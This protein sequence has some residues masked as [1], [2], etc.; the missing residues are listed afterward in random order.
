MKKS[1]LRQ[2]IKKTIEE[3][4]TNPNKVY[5]GS[6]VPPPTK[7]PKPPT[8]PIR[9]CS[10]D[11]YNQFTAAGVAMTLNGIPG[12]ME[13]TDFDMFDNLMGDYG[14]VGMGVYGFIQ[15]TCNND[16]FTIDSLPQL[17]I[18]QS[19]CPNAAELL[20]MYS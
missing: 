8:S 19:C 9:N 4:L 13:I 17:S 5:Q 1:E 7:P 3:Q 18:Y 11:M 2:I 16:D 12:T 6:D 15:N 14:G 10:E 20:Q